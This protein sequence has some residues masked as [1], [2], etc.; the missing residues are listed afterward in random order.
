MKSAKLPE[1]RI[2]REEFAERVRVLVHFVLTEIV[3]DYEK[4][5]VTPVFGPET[6]VFEISS[7]KEDLGKVIGKKGTMAS[8]IRYIVYA[9]YGKYGHKAIVTIN[10]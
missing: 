1:D 4:I 2:S 3:D 8:S 5:K 10:E 7:S 9:M 6:I